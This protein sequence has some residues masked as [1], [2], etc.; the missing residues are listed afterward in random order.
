MRAKFINEY[1][2]Y[3]SIRDINKI[4]PKAFDYFETGEYIK[5]TKNNVYIEI[6]AEELESGDLSLFINDMYTNSYYQNK[7]YA[8]KILKEMCE[9]ADK[10]NMPMSLR[11]SSGGHYNMKGLSQ[12]NLIKWYKKFGF[13]LSPNGSK[14]YDEIFMIREPVN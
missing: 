9:W 14:F 7:G 3:R 1:N 6:G 11:A 13:V 12:E 10:N 2:E 8:S 5:F 4:L